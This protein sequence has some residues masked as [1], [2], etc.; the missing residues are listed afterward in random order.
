MKQ[1]WVYIMFSDRNGTI[2][3]GVTNDLKRRVYEHREGLIEGFTKD[4]N[5]KK[6]GYYEAYESFEAAILRE[7]RLQKWNRLWKLRLL[8]THNPQWD[9]L[10]HYI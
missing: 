10:W 7:K 6:L 4:H 2:Y 9:D 3:I 5:V 8:E 1:A